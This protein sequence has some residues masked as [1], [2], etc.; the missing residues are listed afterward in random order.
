[1]SSQ[2]AEM[3]PNMR[4]C[5]QTSMPGSSTAPDD[6][7]ERAEHPRTTA[8]SRPARLRRGA[9]IAAD[10]RQRSP[11]PANDRRAVSGDRGYEIGCGGMRPTHGARQRRKLTGEVW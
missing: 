3:L 9:P 5:R 6:V 10:R 8:A 4:H 2:L 1:M 7:R 11:H